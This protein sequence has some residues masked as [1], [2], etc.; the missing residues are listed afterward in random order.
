MFIY[1]VQPN[2]SA[3]LLIQLD[4]GEYVMTYHHM[5]QNG[6]ELISFS[7]NRIINNDEMNYLQNWIQPLFNQDHVMNLFRDSFWDRLN[8]NDLNYVNVEQA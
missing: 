8:G 7:Q 5:E 2:Q 1:Q 4:L 3:L 6:R